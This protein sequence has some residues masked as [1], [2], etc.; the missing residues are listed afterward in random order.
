M[1][2]FDMLLV[3]V[4]ASIALAEFEGNVYALSV[5]GSMFSRLLLLPLWRIVREQEDTNS[6][7][8]RPA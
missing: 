3:G 7:I 2:V 6:S 4:E 5:A 1:D 8:T